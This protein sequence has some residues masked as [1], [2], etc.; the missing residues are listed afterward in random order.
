MS[1]A[2]YMYVFLSQRKVST[3][4]FFY[5]RNY[6]VRMGPGPSVV[7]NKKKCP[8]STS[9]FQKTTTKKKPTPRYTHGTIKKKRAIVYYYV[10]IY[11]TANVSA[12]TVEGDQQLFFL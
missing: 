3:L 7:Q 8:T 10:R 2:Y 1:C 12:D 11:T 6:H 5:M 4:L 9:N